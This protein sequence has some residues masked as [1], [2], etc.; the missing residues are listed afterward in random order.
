MSGPTKEREEKTES[1]KCSTERALRRQS[2]QMPLPNLN[3]NSR[4]SNNIN[5]SS[6]SFEAPSINGYRQ[7]VI[8]G[9][10]RAT[11]NRQQ[12]ANQ[13][14]SITTSYGRSINLDFKSE[15]LL[16]DNSFAEP[17]L[18]PRTPRS[19]R[20][21]QIIIYNNTNNN[22][23]NNNHNG[24]DGGNSNNGGHHR[25]MMRSESSNESYV[26]SSFDPRQ[27]ANGRKHG[28]SQ[29]MESP[30]FVEARSVMSSF[31]R[32][33][34]LSRRNNNNNN[35]SNTN[36]SSSNKRSMDGGSDGNGVGGGSGGGHNGA[37]SSFSDFHNAM[38]RPCSRETARAMDSLRA[39][40]SY[41][42][43]SSDSNT[44]SNNNSNNSNYNRNKYE[45]PLLSSQIEM[46]D[47]P[48]EAD[49][50]PMYQ[51]RQQQQQQ[52]QPVTPRVRASKL[53]STLELD[54]KANTSTGDSNDE[55]M[56]TKSYPI[57]APR[58]LKKNSMYRDMRSDA[59]GA[60]T[61]DSVDD[62]EMSS[63]ISDHRLVNN[64]STLSQRQRDRT[65]NG[66]VNGNG[67]GKGSSQ[68]VPSRKF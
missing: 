47:P 45:D 11:P 13:P 24:N 25:N 23:N 35:N 2:A 15:S 1:E 10:Q 42:F 21:R 28:S 52:P 50:K 57:P 29:E 59:Y 27:T 7:Q 30:S 63:S 38:S 67:N 19:V 12:N 43:R 36:K 66:N 68:Y 8:D 37:E 6:A 4:S 34:T 55:D 65:S 14:R 22:N 56:L 61:A 16:M 18:P 48:S 33:S 62:V 3:F 39:K 26:P 9:I 60:S 31:G 64:S 20:S 44:T 49:R 40:S 51:Q 41:F 58:T 17:L 5:N 54:L 32:M 53:R 46:S